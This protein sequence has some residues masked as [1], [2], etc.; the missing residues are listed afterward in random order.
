VSSGLAGINV[1]V[2]ALLPGPTWSEGGGAFVEK[3]AREQGISVEQCEA[4]FVKSARQAR[5]SSA[6]STLKK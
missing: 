4:E 6:S 3:L 5:P 1:T 2:N